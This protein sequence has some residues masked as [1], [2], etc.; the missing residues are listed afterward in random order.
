MKN[1]F[2]NVGFLAKQIL[3]VPPFQFD[4]CKF[5]VAS[6]LQPSTPTHRESRFNNHGIKN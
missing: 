5:N 1:Q 2:P 4:T 3:G 6:V